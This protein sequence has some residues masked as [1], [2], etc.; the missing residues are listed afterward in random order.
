M[1][2]KLPHSSSDNG[3]PNE[4]INV[5]V[6][7]DEHECQAYQIAL[8]LDPKINIT[9]FNSKNLTKY[10]NILM[11]KN[12]FN[13]T[14]ILDFNIL[15]SNSISLIKNAVLSG[16]GLF[17]QS[18]DISHGYNQSMINEFEEVI[19]FVPKFDG[20]G[21]PIKVKSE[22]ANIN[23]INT[24][25][26]EDNGQFGSIFLRKIGFI[27]LPQLLY[28]NDAEPKS[29]TSVLVTT[30]TGEPIL[31]V[32]QFGSGRVIG[33]TAPVINK[34]NTNL[35]D[36]P[37]FTYMIYSFAMWSSSIDNF[38]DYGQWPYSPLPT[39]T[40]RHFV[41]VIIIII[42]FITI[43]GF[44]YMRRKSKIKPLKI[45]PPT[46]MELKALEKA[47]IDY[48]IDIYEIGGK[49]D[50]QQ[51]EKEEEIKTQLSDVDG[52]KEPA[53]ES[54]RE[55]KK[56]RQ[57]K[58]SEKISKK[59]LKDLGFEEVGYHKP[60]TGF[61]LMFYLS[62][63]LLLPLVVIVMYILPTFI[64]TDPAQMG[65]TFITGNIFSAIFIAGDFGLAQAFDR[66]VGENY[67]RDPKKALK[68]VQFFVWFQMLSGIV[69]T[70]GIAII[71]LYILPKSTSLAFMSYQFVAKAFVQ[72]PGIG[73]LWTHS[74]KAL[75]RTDKEQLV[76]LIGIIFFDIIGMALFAAYFLELGAKNPMI[77][78]VIGASLGITMGEVFKTF[79]LLL[80]S[81]IV[82]GRMDKRFSIWSMFRVDFDLVLAKETL[83]FGLKS[84]L[85]TVIYLFGNF[86]FTIIIMFK[87]D[88][89]TYW[90]TFIG[91]AT[92]LLYPITFMNIL[93]E[94]S[95]PTTA[96][97]YGN[98]CYKLTEAY[99]SFG[100]K[101]FGVF[102]SLVFA[103]FFF[104]LSKMLTQILPP[105]YKPMGFFIGFYSITKLISGLG[106]FSRLFLVA[107]DRVGL[108]ILFVLIE[109]IIRI[110]LLLL[111]IDRIAH[112]E[113]LLI[114]G[115][116]PGVIVKVLLTW[117]YTNKKIIRVK[118][119]IWQTVIAP[120]I[121]T[122]GFVIVG[123][124]LMKFYYQLISGQSALVPTIIFSFIIFMG[125]TITI[126]P[127]ILALAGGWDKETMRQ[128]EFAISH[129]GPSKPFSYI[130]LK[131]TQFGNKISSL[132][133]RFPIDFKEATSEIE[134]LMRLKIKRHDEEIQKGL[135]S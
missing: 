132:Y 28:V 127:L 81:G 5:A 13:S 10:Q 120:L 104:F 87:L 39:A 131:S 71:G 70:G 31:M 23:N 121:A 56:S 83:W 79:G 110:T 4:T 106:D 93:Y 36:W 19:P 45:R 7:S 95:L 107:I 82:F 42:S 122:I 88:N 78:K 3:R 54:G 61:S 115:E 30:S 94:S 9:L 21:T 125:L 105:L 118:I 116:L 135:A 112:P 84:M 51:N 89:Y 62:L 16:M 101:Y 11:V 91:S 14:F 26:M 33:L 103:S 53:K 114:F 124:I 98:K 65:I 35:G 8:N 73:Y 50:A 134:Y 6:I 63:C 49:K 32:N 68:Y 102:A 34:T 123:T 119:Y 29:N 113:F 27:S 75:Q 46:K 22:Y 1:K 60:L 38:E 117:V 43:A 80:I 126:Y 133:N 72:W 130:F 40:T 74:L 66:F 59:K 109:Q 12:Y 100:W 15:T 129:S 85:S 97:A 86:T 2:V 64:L 90:G 55:N 69:Q 25:V 99:I 92:F 18:N 108:Y 67:I 37:Y 111:L 58:G 17:F 57:S 24:R 44:I 52:N 128:L 41:L 48:G 47:K 77:G 20:N 96:E 76:G